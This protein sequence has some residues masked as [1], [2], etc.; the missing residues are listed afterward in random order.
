[1]TPPEPEDDGVAPPD[2]ESFR[3]RFHAAEVRNYL[4]AGLAAL[5]MVFVVLFA[6]GSDLGGLLLVV[7]G[8]AGMVL[9]W[10]GTPPLF[11]VVLLY[12]LVFPYGVPPADYDPSAIARGSFRVGD[13]ILAAAVLVYVACHYRVYAL[14]ARAVPADTPDPP[15]GEEKPPRRAPGNVRP[16][17]V[18][19]VVAIAVAAAIAGQ[20]VW[21]GLTTATIDVLGDIPVR[22]DR[23]QPRRG[24]PDGRG[25]A[26]YATRLL[27]LVGLVAGGALL[28]RVVFGYWRLRRLGPAEGGLVVQ[29]AGWDETRREDA[30]VAG[31]RA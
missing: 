4:F 16:E 26:G 10:P 12:F 2:P 14:T 13:M 9:R 21:W 25:Y 8:S 15:R 27:L 17:E 29:E 22:F 30:R 24:S 31:W 19:R 18:T 5:A 11:L 1:M 3:G 23:P 28:G 20:F 6:R 7:L